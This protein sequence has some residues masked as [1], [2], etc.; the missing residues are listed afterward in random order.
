[1]LVQSS[2]SLQK[3][4]PDIQRSMTP[5]KSKKL[6]DSS[7]EEEEEEE[8][9]GEE[10]EEEE[11]DDDEEEERRDKKVEAGRWVV[12][13]DCRIFLKLV[14]AQDSSSSLRFSSLR[15]QSNRVNVVCVWTIL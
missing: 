2:S 13:V 7:D 15:H 12:L 8:E 1:M 4:I 14:L 3:S 9:E 5:V 6:L 10:E 11:E